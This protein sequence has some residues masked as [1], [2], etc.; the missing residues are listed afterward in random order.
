VEPNHT[1]ARELG[2]SLNHSILCCIGR[3]TEMYTEP[4]FFFNVYGAQESIPRNEFRQPNV[5]WRA[6][7]ITLFLFGS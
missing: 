5:A 2:V 3:P 6:G 1:T 4:V 7:T